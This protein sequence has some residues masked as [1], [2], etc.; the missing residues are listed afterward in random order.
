MKYAI[1]GA[2]SSPSQPCPQSSPLICLSQLNRVIGSTSVGGAVSKDTN[3]PTTIDKM[4]PI[5]ENHTYE[6][7]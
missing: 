1:G 3:I 5:M 4:N 2:L 6:M 7:L